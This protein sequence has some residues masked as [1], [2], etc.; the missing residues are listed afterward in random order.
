MEKNTNDMKKNH[1]CPVDG[2]C[3]ECNGC[4]GMCMRGGSPR[5]YWRRHILVLILGVIAAFFVGMKL[6]EIKGYMMASYGMMPMRHHGW[7][8]QDDKDMRGD[9]TM[10]PNPTTP[11]PAQ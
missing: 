5:K 8:M 1:T 3:C 11:P 4:G 10:M 9:P 2:H 6:G 7:M